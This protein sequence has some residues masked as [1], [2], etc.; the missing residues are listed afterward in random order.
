MDEIWDQVLGPIPEA[1]GLEDLDKLYPED[2][3]KPQPDE[4]Q[5]PPLDQLP[6]LEPLPAL[7]ELPEIE[8]EVAET[9]RP[10]RSGRKILFLLILIGIGVGI[11]YQQ[12][13][14]DS[15]L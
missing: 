10:R 2:R 13:Y 14:L 4:P 15:L 9:T 1:P 6:P 12:G 5:L 8:P 3:I 7:A 11:A